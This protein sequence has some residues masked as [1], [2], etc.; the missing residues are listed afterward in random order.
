MA[1]ANLLSYTTIFMKSKIRQVCKKAIKCNSM[2]WKEQ[3]PGP[4]LSSL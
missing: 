3:N 1:K 4:A 2:R